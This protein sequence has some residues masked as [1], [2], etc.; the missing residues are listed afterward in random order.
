MIE[1][2][3]KELWKDTTTQ[4]LNKV[5]MNNIVTTKSL[6]WAGFLQGLQID[7]YELYSGFGS[8]LLDINLQE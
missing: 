4:R 3:L 6:D 1:G 5:Y 2:K 8:Y 7:M